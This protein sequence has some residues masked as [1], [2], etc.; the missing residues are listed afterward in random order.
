MV[1]NAR[2]KAPNVTGHPP[3]GLTTLGD[4]GKFHIHQPPETRLMPF[5]EG[6]DVS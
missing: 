1:W 4:W 3:A 2:I 5:Q 6:D